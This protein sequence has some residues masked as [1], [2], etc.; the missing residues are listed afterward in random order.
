MY[1]SEYGR[2]RL[3]GGLK[4]IEPSDE[5]LPDSKTTFSIYAEP[6]PLSILSKHGERLAAEH[7]ML[8]WNLACGEVS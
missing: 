5:G 7:H 6:A 2:W 8:P 4:D 3:P 1:L